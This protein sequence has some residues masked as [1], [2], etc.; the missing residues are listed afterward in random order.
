MLSFKN[1]FSAVALLVL[2]APAFGQVAPPGGRLTL[3]QG[4]PIQMA[5]VSGASTIYYDALGD[6]PSYVPIPNG[7]GGFTSV[8][9]PGG[10]LSIGLSATNIAAGNAYDVFLVESG[11]T[12]EMCVGGAGWSSG[13][14]SGTTVTHGT[15][16]LHR[17]TGYWTNA[18]SI[19]HCYGGA[20]GTTDYGPISADGA[21]WV[22]SFT[23]SAAGQVTMAPHPS[24]ALGG[25]NTVC[26][27]ANIYNRV[28]TRCVSEDSN[29]SWNTQSSDASHPVPCDQAYDTVGLNRVTFLDPI[30]DRKWIVYANL[31]ISGANNTVGYW[32]LVAIGLN[33]TAGASGTGGHGAYLEQQA[34]PP[35]G[36]VYAGSAVHGSLTPD[37][38]PVGSNYLQCMEYSNGNSVFNAQDYEMMVLEAWM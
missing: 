26:G 15:F 9:I 5:N 4:Y 36:A 21:L 25:S 7:L 28:L 29:A 1:I 27:L 24:A 3:Q 22:G 32:G 6:K 23:A 19:S 37:T 33:T 14:F 35:S 8:A 30:G 2:S 11:A 38:P 34:V 17:T 31:S 12:L 13:S 18:D 10:E 16:H 20:S